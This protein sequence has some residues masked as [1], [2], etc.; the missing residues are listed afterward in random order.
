M[1][2]APSFWAWYKAHRGALSCSF[3]SWSGAGWG[4]GDN[5]HSA[6]TRYGWLTGWWYEESAHLLGDICHMWYS[7]ILCSFSQCWSQPSV[8]IQWPDSE[9]LPTI[10]KNIIRRIHDEKKR[11]SKTEPCEIKV[12][13]EEVVPTK[14]ERIQWRKERW[15]GPRSQGELLLTFV[16]WTQQL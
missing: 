4:W 10:W 7:V 15:R 8:L 13:V 5:W 6:V 12:Q 16:R 14:I 1:S 3:F 9:L 11:G 2:L